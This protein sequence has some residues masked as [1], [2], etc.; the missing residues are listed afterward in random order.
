MAGSCGGLLLALTA[1]LLL[2][3]CAPKSR[4]VDAPALVRQRG[5]TGRGRGERIRL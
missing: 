3:A 5:R 2:P 4:Q 1:L